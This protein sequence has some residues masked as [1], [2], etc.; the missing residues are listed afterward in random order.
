MSAE[1]LP[2]FK[3]YIGAQASAGH[4]RRMAASAPA[5]TISR[6]CGAGAL[7][8]A[9]MTADILTDYGR[10]FGLPP[11]TIFDRELV[12]H[13]ISEHKLPKHAARY[14][15]EDR[16]PELRTAF[17][18]LLGLHPSKVALVEFTNETIL[19]LARAGHAIIVGR[20]GSIVTARLPNV[21]HLRLVAPLGTRVEE[22]QKQLGVGKEAALEHVLKT[23]RARARYLKR[24]FGARIDDPVGY[25]LTIN[26][27][28]MAFE[29]AARLIADGTVKLMERAG[30]G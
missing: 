9:R 13:V 3:G 4:G 27:G 23:D 6:E 16:V 24:N 10:A 8:V 26:T 20:G 15:P 7:T 22:M 28:R 2:G 17:E 14:M 11:W 18:E 19:R 29:A 21:V 25:H 1:T 30:V 5:I 12:Q